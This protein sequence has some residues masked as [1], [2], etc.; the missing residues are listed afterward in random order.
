MPS[1]NKCQNIHTTYVPQNADGEDGEIACHQ[2]HSAIEEVCCFTHCPEIQIYIDVRTVVNPS[3]LLEAVRA[4][5]ASQDAQDP[6]CN[7]RLSW[8]Q[9]QLGKQSR[10]LRSPLPGQIKLY[11]TGNTSWMEVGFIGLT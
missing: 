5:K 9:I 3:M 10:R 8:A 4:Y 1:C 2:D 11:A 6:D 7:L